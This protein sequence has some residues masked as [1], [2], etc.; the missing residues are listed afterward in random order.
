M[1]AQTLDSLLDL[2]SSL[3]AK[4]PEMAVTGGGGRHPPPQSSTSADVEEIPS[5]SED[6]DHP[7]VDQEGGGS[8]GATATGTQRKRK[9]TRE[10]VGPHHVIHMSLMGHG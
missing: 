9:R 4:V 10:W 5:D 7:D 6:G 8:G 1:L 2:Q 3:L